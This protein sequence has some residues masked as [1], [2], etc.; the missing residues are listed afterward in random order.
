MHEVSTWAGAAL[1]LAVPV[2]GAL[3]FAVGRMVPTR[4]ALAD[5][6]DE[7]VRDGRD[8][9]TEYNATAG[10]GGELLPELPDWD[11][12]NLALL[13]DDEVPGEVTGPFTITDLGGPGPASADPRYDRPAQHHP[14]LLVELTDWTML[15][16]GVIPEDAYPR[17]FSD[18]PLPPAAVLEREW[19]WGK[20]AW[21][22]VEFRAW[23]E[24]WDSRTGAAGRAA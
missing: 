20:A 13:R 12:D 7:G 5:A 17:R 23:M 6:Y 16:Q 15:A 19:S 21:E 24:S 1:V 9:I 3:T 18:L 14:P 4:R 2:I 8:E 11:D 22:I 10:G